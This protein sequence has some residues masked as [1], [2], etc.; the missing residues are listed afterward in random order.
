MKKVL[1]K[2]SPFVLLTI[3]LL[4]FR[5]NLLDDRFILPHNYVKEINNA[6]IL[7][8]DSK[9]SS[10]FNDSILDKF[11]N[12]KIYNLSFWAASPANIMKLVKHIEIK[13]TTIFLNISSRIYINHGFGDEKYRLKEIL[14]GN[15]IDNYL[16]YSKKN[17]PGKWEYEKTK[18]GSIYFTHIKRP[19]SL[20][21]RNIDSSTI[22]ND[23]VND[24][25][26]NRF[27]NVTRSLLL[28]L[29]EYLK[30][31]NNEIY[32]IDLPEREC[33][34]EW[35]KYAEI[36]LFT[37]VDSLTKNKIVDFGVYPDRLFYDSHHLNKFGSIRFTNEFIERFKDV[38]H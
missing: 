5:N 20:Y 18:Y 31:N 22:C 26:R 10:D 24:S 27:N 17:G 21:N 11:S 25:V 29:Y 33:F 19:Y 30:K 37:K 14:N 15:L 28:E 12:K 32:L 23:I 4:S 6:I 36:K 13:N 7:L 35:V 1:L 34:N 2:V 8:G 9:T 3:V 16:M 38:L